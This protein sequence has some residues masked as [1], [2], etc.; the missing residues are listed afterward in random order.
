VSAAGIQ[1]GIGSAIFQIVTSVM[2]DPFA[3][4]CLISA[5]C[6]GLMTWLAARLLR[7]PLAAG[8][9]STRP[10]ILHYAIMAFTGITLTGPLVIALRTGT[11]AIHFARTKTSI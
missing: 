5:G 8:A 3:L 2:G 4:N 10:T 1:F 9:D 7:S 11:L 6:M